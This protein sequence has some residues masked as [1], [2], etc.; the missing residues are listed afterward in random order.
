M[1]KNVFHV[2]HINRLKKHSERIKNID[3]GLASNLNYDEIK[4]PVEE[5]DF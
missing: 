1:I 3:R 4:F 2:A 5:K